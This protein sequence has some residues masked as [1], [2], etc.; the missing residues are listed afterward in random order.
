[1]LIFY[2]DDQLPPAGFDYAGTA[3]AESF[4][5]TLKSFATKLE[6]R[7]TKFP[8]VLNARSLSFIYSV[9]TDLPR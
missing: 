9:E 8:F 7:L 2:G 3:T 6:I 4:G 1:L 5:S